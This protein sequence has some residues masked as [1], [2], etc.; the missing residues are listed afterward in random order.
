[1]K[2]TVAEFRSNTREILNAVDQGADVQIERYGKLYAIKAT[3]RGDSEMPERHSVVNPPKATGISGE[4]YNSYEKKALDLA[5]PSSTIL[6]N[7]KVVKKI[8]RLD[9]PKKIKK[10]VAEELKLCPDHAQPLPCMVKG[11][12][13]GR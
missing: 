2:Y 3:V 7:G 4:Q 10:N 11:C 8:S 5:D 9:K 12:K 13:H 6:E 1:M